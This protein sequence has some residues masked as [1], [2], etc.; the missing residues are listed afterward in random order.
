[1][2]CWAALFFL[3]KFKINLVCI[4]CVYN[5]GFMKTKQARKIRNYRVADVPYEAAMKKAAKTE[6]PLAKRIEEFVCGY[7]GVMAPFL[8][9]ESNKKKK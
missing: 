5:F 9:K 1:M 4:Y 8:I 3:R 6:K 2:L 7:A